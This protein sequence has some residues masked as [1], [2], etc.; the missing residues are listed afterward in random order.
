VAREK[1]ETGETPKSVKLKNGEGQEKR[2]K[3]ETSTFHQ[4]LTQDLS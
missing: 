1:E 2:E 4:I 3:D